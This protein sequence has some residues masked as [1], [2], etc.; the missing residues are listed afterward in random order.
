MGN[1]GTISPNLHEAIT[2]ASKKLMAGGVIA[3][4]TE[5]VFGLGC[6]PLN[7]SALERL[8][9]L[10][11]RASHKGFIVVAANE[12]QL[13]NLIEPLTE[14]SA[15]KIR[16]SWPGPTTW[17]VAAKKNLP[18]VLTGGRDTLAVRICAHTVVQKLCHQFG[19]A[20]VSTSANLSQQAELRTAADVSRVFADRLDCIIDA[21]TGGADSPS[22]IFDAATLTQLR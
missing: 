21:P 10:K 16:A 5:A 4:P 13:E 22:K 15:S 1:N 2:T 3:Y 20:I 8:L 18:T 14:P 6:D 17:V 9:E 7:L 12:S 19:G 11:G